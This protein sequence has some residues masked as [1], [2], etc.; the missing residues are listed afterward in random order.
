MLLPVEGTLEAAEIEVN[1][2]ERMIPD[3]VAF[4]VLRAR[5]ESPD[6]PLLKLQ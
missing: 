5:P 3:A 4:G 1:P 2:H 6:Y